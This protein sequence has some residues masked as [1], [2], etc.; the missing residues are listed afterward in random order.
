MSSAI[1]PAEPKSPA[2]AAPRLVTAA[3]AKSYP[4][5]DGEL[6]ILDGVDLS[7]AA[8]EAVV[9]TGPSGVGKSTLLYLLGAIEEPSSGTVSLD[10]VD[11]FALDEAG[12]AAF[13]NREVGFVFQDHHLLPQ[14]TVLENVLLPLLASRTADA[15]DAERAAGLLDAVGLADRRTHKPAALSG[16]ERQRAALCRALI[17]EPKLVLA[18]E[19]TGNLDPATAE[20]VGRLLLDLAA[21]QNVILVCVTHSMSLAERF[22]RHLVLTDR[23]LEPAVAGLADA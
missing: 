16:G 13:R 8:G 1:A 9:V 11:P 4:A 3:L 7:L 23:R 6:T 14:C 5:A 20:T 18:D 10:G 21:E 15:A 19:P 12:R 22:P 17:N 2:E